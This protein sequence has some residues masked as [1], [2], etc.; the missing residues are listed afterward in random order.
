[1]IRRITLHNFMAHKDTVIEP[2]DGLTVLVGPN[3]CG[4][5]AVV[6]ALQILCHNDN[7]TYVTRHN[8]RECTVTV[9]TSDGH[10]VQWSRKNNSPRYT[11]DGQPF[12][13]LDRNSIP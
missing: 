13:R 2:A 3:N 1:M 8:E 4:K 12:D 5:S 10:I 11:V 7:S 9:E 6:A